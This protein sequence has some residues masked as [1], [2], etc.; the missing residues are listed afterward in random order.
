MLSLF[1]SFPPAPLACNIVQRATS[2]IQLLTHSFGNWRRKGERERGRITAREVLLLGREGHQ[3]CLHEG[4]GR[5]GEGR[6]GRKED[7]R[8]PRLKAR[9]GKGTKVMDDYDEDFADRVGEGRGGQRDRVYFS[10][11][12]CLAS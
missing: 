12:C 8:L 4:S 3:S 1:L 6:E 7:T 5:E 2:I 10:G 11:V 9:I